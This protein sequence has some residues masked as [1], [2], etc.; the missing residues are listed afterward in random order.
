MPILNPPTL[1]NH[2]Q[3]NEAD[4][5]RENWALL[6]HAQAAAT[7]L[8]ETSDEKLIEG[9]CRAITSQYPYDVAWVG[10]A[11]NDPG[12]T[13]KV[14]G[15]SGVAADYAQGIKVS[16][17]EDAPSGRGP[18]GSC[19][20]S[21]LAVIVEDT[22]TDSAFEPWRERALKFNLRSCVAVPIPM[23]G[24][25]LS[26][27]LTV[28]ASV[29]NAFGEVELSLFKSLASDIGYGLVSLERKATLDK[30]IL[31]RQNAQEKLAAALRATIEAMSKT[32][33]W[34]DPY[35][36]GH[37]ERVANISVVIAKKLGWDEDRIKGL[38]M[39]ATVHDIGKVAI[40]SEILSKP[41]Q[42]TE[43]EMK[44]VRE[45]VDVGYQI[46]KDIPFAW[47]IAEMVRQHHE[48]LDG[49][50][51]PRGLIGDQICQEAR[52]LAVADTLEAMASHRPY[53]AGKGVK[54]ALKQIKEESGISL[55]VHVVDALL[56]VAKERGIVEHLVS[57]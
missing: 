47:P 1:T 56:A 53:R 8:H 31:E 28:Y 11:Q 33:A 4:L 36:A 43:L 24:A 48:R 22:Q 45:H 35:T 16:W 49:S 2:A 41:S 14:A 30:E 51:Y 39:A 40:P 25:D 15:A 21:G 52:I 44:L 23:D 26:G 50:G 17:S 10:F 42:L 9:I 5:L 6:A 29:P 12:K 18:V 27:A 32:M 13:I 19:I 55:D 3:A 57:L 37:Q 54:A 46:L 7:L 20:R 34:R 38:Y